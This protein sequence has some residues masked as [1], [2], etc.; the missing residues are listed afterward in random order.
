MEKDD[1]PTD[2]LY[3]SLQ[4]QRE[5]VRDPLVRQKQSEQFIEP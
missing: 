1:T 3:R 4:L 5:A 2:P